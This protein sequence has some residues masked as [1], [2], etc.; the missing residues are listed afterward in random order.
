MNRFLRG[1]AG[2]FR[3]GNSARRFDQIMTYATQRP[4]HRC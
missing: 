4:W 2:Y 3:Y 1:W